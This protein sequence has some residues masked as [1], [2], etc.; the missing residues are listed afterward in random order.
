MTDNIICFF[1][2][3]RTDIVPSAH[4]ALYLPKEPPKEYI[5]SSQLLTYPPS[6]LYIRVGQKNE[7]F[8]ISLYAPKDWLVDTSKKRF[9]N[10]FL[11][12]V[13]G[14]SFA[15]PLSIFFLRT[16]KKRREKRGSQ[17]LKKCLESN[18]RKLSIA[19]S[20]H[21]SCQNCLIFRPFIKSF[22]MCHYCVKRR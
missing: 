10:A 4:V 14:R 18:S 16:D 11:L 13:T 20:A 3:N 5:N 9:P 15:L 6:C 17:F 19:I 22:F 8:F 1:C 21:S 7:C 12:N 2:W